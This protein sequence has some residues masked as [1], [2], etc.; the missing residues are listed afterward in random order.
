LLDYVNSE[1]VEVEIGKLRPRLDESLQAKHDLETQFNQVADQLAK[2]KASTDEAAGAAA[3]SRSSAVIA[4]PIDNSEWQT[5]V[6]RVS[7]RLNREVAMMTSATQLAKPSSS[8]SSGA[9]AKHDEDQKVSPPSSSIM[10]APLLSHP[11]SSTLRGGG[12]HVWQLSFIASPPD[13][14]GNVL[15]V[16]AHH[17]NDQLMVQISGHELALILGVVQSKSDKSVP[18]INDQEGLWRRV[19]DR[20]VVEHI[21]GHNALAIEL[22]S[23]R[24]PALVHE[25]LVD[26]GSS[27]TEVA[28]ELDQIL[29]QVSQLHCQWLANMLPLQARVQAAEAAV[30]NQNHTPSSPSASTNA[31]EVAQIS[32]ERDSL[33]ST[34]AG[35]TELNSELIVE[36]QQLERQ[37]S[38]MANKPPELKRI[39]STAREPAA[40]TYPDGSATLPAAWAN[41]ITTLGSMKAITAG[42]PAM[43]GMASAGTMVAPWQSQGAIT[44][45]SPAPSASSSPPSTGTPSGSSGGHGGKKIT[46]ADMELVK[47]QLNEQKA[48]VEE[49]KKKLAIME[50]QLEEAR[51]KAM[52]ASARALFGGDLVNDEKRIKAREEELDRLKAK[53]A[54]D[55][56]ALEQGKA[57]LARVLR[58]YKAKGGLSADEVEW[59]ADQE[60]RLGVRELVDRFEDVAARERLALVDGSPGQGGRPRALSRGKKDPSS[61]DTHDK[62][63]GSLPPSD[64]HTDTKVTTPAPAPASTSQSEKEALQA[65]MLEALRKTNADLREAQV[66]LTSELEAALASSHS[67]SESLKAA[68]AK[69]AEQAKRIKELQDTIDAVEEEMEA[70]RKAHED[71][72]ES[73]RHSRDDLLHQLDVAKL[74]VEEKDKELKDIGDKD[75]EWNEKE[76][77]WLDREVDLE[78]DVQLKEEE[79][80]KADAR[81]LKS[82]QTADDWEEKAIHWDDERQIMAEKLRTAELAAQHA[83]EGGSSEAARQLTELRREHDEQEELITKLSGEKKALTST[84]SQLREQVADLAE[85]THSHGDNGPKLEEALATIA[86]LKAK[87]KSWN[88]EE[89]TLNERLS[90]AEEKARGYE[91]K[92]REWSRRETD[93]KLREQRAD[94]ARHDVIRLEKALAE[95]EQQLNDNVRKRKQLE[96]RAIA[97]EQHADTVVHESDAKT[98]AAER[99]QRQAQAKVASVEQAL[100]DLQQEHAHAEREIELRNNKVRSLE[101]QAQVAIERAEVEQVRSDQ[102]VEELKAVRA[103]LASRERELTQRSTPKHSTNDGDAQSTGTA[104][105][106]DVAASTS[107]VM[108][109]AV[110]G[111]EVV[112]LRGRVDALVE[113]NSKLQDEVADTK[114]EVEKIARNLAAAE[115]RHNREVEEARANQRAAASRI[116][117]A[118]REHRDAMQK[119]NEDHQRA[120]TAAIQAKDEVIAIVATARDEADRANDERKTALLQLARLTGTPSSSPSV[121]GN[122]AGIAERDRRIA[123]EVRR[124]KELES[125]LK[126]GIADRSVLERKVEDLTA[127][128]TELENAATENRYTADSLLASART[129]ADQVTAQLTSLREH[130]NELKSQVRALQQQVSDQSTT[131]AEAKESSSRSGDIERLTAQVER[132]SSERDS[133]SAR[134]EA[135]QVDIEREQSTVARIRREAEKAARDHKSQ[136]ERLERSIAQHKAELAEINGMLPKWNE[137]NSELTNT[138]S[139][140]NEQQE[141]L[142]ADLQSMRAAKR[143]LQR[144][145]ASLEAQLASIRHERDQA[146]DTHHRTNEAT[147]E[148]WRQEAKDSAAR[149]ERA[150]DQVTEA[151]NG[152]RNVEEQLERLQRSVTQKDEEIRS[153]QAKVAASR[154]RKTPLRVTIDP[155]N[156]S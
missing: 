82:Q 57:D 144:D 26:D 138:I 104:F 134:S 123:S 116:T 45:I 79:R 19:A 97:A 68:E 131:I 80:A 115:A 124:V 35:L 60:R 101:E 86:Q 32:A 94:D 61:T 81:W 152:R 46:T 126:S 128:I 22:H 7:S 111:E 17:D 59:A 49:G 107:S 65:S 44:E 47:R 77:K 96:E 118:K 36:K 143:A 70:E 75:K 6:H 53:L 139:T 40:S 156:Q 100:A 69:L 54:Q 132:L 93:M 1:K 154:E 25:S 55:R 12:S 66:K 9:N 2:H 10:G 109:G 52:A 87:S 5:L 146:T 41:D 122:D 90:S 50:R 105:T 121:G 43:G 33:R 103:S 135:L 29:G 24:S 112:K 18:V 48:L 15:T 71:E 113:E 145:K 148:R 140:L 73:L 149:A 21:D 120:L 14:D 13:H 92:V 38:H 99:L 91:A 30:A 98:K 42:S 83:V 11:L 114:A 137:S 108:P 147:V 56:T 88:D 23:P 31:A 89:R 110:A 95:K 127:H 130:N 28:T 58:L 117:I 72:V 37:L 62:G 16:R 142:K 4:K 63:T 67:S 76:S 133:L 84:I 78:A 155:S 34:L 153:L 27:L 136:V 125:Q 141:R 151:E 106:F 74:L 102:L 20:L 64:D 150:A 8:T 119:L 85:K 3:A 51:S 39:S 129:V